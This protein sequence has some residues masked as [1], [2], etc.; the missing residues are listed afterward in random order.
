M[1]VFYGARCRTPS[2][3]APSRQRRELFTSTAQFI[4]SSGEQPHCGP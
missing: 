1:K 4:L 2:A 3:M